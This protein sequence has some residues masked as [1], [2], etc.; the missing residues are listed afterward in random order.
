VAVCLLP[1][2][3]AGSYGGAAIDAVDG[4]GA[5]K[6]P[7]ARATLGWFGAA[8]AADPTAVTLGMEYGG[9][10]R[11]AP[12]ESMDGRSEEWRRAGARGVFSRRLAFARSLWLFTRAGARTAY[13][14]RGIVQND[15]C[16]IL[17]A[18]RATLAH[19][20]E[21][22]KYAYAR[23]INGFLGVTLF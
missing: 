10:K 2:L 22:P 23:Y 15:A 18:A 1:A 6:R 14:V 7:Q 8:E 4:R 21:R 5:V 13:L 12:L 19:L 17:F 20:L 16:G 9:V 3:G 11:A